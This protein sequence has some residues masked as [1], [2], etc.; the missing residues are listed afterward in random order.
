MKTR[1]L[2]R[3]GTLTVFSCLMAPASVLAAG[4]ETFSHGCEVSAGTTLPQ[5]GQGQYRFLGMLRVFQAAFYT[6]PETANPL[7]DIPRCLVIRYD[8]DFS[9]EQFQG[10]TRDGIRANL[11]AKTYA[12]LAP[13]IED[14]VRLYADVKEGDRYALI[15]VPGQGTKLTLN[16]KPR[17]TIAGRDF[18]AALFSIWLGENSM[19]KGLRR[20]LLGT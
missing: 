19:S 5:R 13:R 2:L 17:G 6:A 4:G 14:Y 3:V 12:S 7:G 8:R 1:A 20:D 10:V 11:D 15:Y 9:A 16:G 18:S